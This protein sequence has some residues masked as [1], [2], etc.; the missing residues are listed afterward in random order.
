MDFSADIASSYQS[1]EEAVGVRGRTFPKVV[2]CL[3]V[4]IPGER[5]ERHSILVTRSGNQR[6]SDILR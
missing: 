1:T 4:H 6:V 5:R 2:H 3:S